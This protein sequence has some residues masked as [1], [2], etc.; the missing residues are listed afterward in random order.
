MTTS[1]DIAARA[2]RTAQ[3]ARKY[4]RDHPDCALI[5]W[6]ADQLITATE[7][8]VEQVSELNRLLFRAEC[9][10]YYADEAS[11]RERVP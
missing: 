10:L 6:R 3:E 9:E 1:T 4:L 2:R 11:V 5:R 8:L 7:E